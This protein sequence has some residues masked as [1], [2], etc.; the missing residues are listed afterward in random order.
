MLGIITSI[1]GLIFV[2]LVFNAILHTF[3]GVGKITLGLILI[4]FSRICDAISWVRV[5]AINIW[6]HLTVK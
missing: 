4:G 6:Y 1:V 5:Y 3:I 2:A